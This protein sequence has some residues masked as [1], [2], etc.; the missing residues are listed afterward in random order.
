M[1]FLFTSECVT[2]GHPDKLSDSISDAILDAYLAKDPRCRVAVETFVTNGFCLIGGEVGS[3]VD[4]LW[5]DAPAIARETMKRIGYGDPRAGYPA[6][7]VGVMN[8]IGRQ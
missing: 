7:D 6:D 3:A 5:I 1:A 4:G 8:A 2:A